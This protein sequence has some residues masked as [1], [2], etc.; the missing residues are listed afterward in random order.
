MSPERYIAAILN[1]FVEI[2]SSLVFIPLLYKVKIS[3]TKELTAR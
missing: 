1:I 3:E 2:E